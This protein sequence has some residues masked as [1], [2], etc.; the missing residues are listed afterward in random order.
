MA[1]VYERVRQFCKDNPSEVTCKYCGDIR[2]Y[3]HTCFYEDRCPNCHSIAFDCRKSRHV[4]LKDV[5]ENVIVRSE[6]A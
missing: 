6:W 3:S 1:T 5:P 2:Y 4:P